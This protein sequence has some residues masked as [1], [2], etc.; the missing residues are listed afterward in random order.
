MQEP[1]K[2]KRPRIGYQCS[3]NE[4]PMRIE[5]LHKIQP[6]PFER[7]SMAGFYT[8]ATQPSSQMDDLFNWLEEEKCKPRC[9]LGFNDGHDAFAGNGMQ[10]FV[11]YTPSLTEVN[12]FA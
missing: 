3:E 8:P 7:D 11:L 2:H 4:N 9:H 5:Q 1:A 6:V 12:F 10:D